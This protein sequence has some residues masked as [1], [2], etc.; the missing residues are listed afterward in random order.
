MSVKNEW[1]VPASDFTAALKPFLQTEMQLQGTEKLFYTSTAVPYLSDSKGKIVLLRRYQGSDG[2]NATVD[3][4]EDEV[5]HEPVNGNPWMMIQD[6]FGMSCDSAEKKWSDFIKTFLEDAQ[7]VP[8]PPTPTDVWWLNFTNASG[9]L[10]PATFAASIN[11]RLQEWLEKEFQLA[12]GGGAR[13]GTIVMDFPSPRAVDLLIA[14]N[15]V[16]DPTVVN[17][18]PAY[19]IRLANDKAGIGVSYFGGD[20]WNYPQAYPGGSMGH[21]LNKVSGNPD[22]G[23]IYSGDQVRLLSTQFTNDDYVYICEDIDNLDNTYY[24]Q[25]GGDEG[26]P[27]TAVWQIERVSAESDSTEP[28]PIEFGETVRFSN[29]YSP[30]NCLCARTNK[31][32]SSTPLNERSAWILE[33]GFDW[34]MEA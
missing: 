27:G 28:P 24:N 7:A 11:A 26:H 34:T 16:H 12:S 8:E 20:R 4:P 13:L 29:V 17:S 22:M 19:K 9:G 32:I 3:W 21:A 33:G 1:N 18:G 2:I 31:W 14:W 10:W 30:V 23:R 6:V 5:T 25:I 15:V